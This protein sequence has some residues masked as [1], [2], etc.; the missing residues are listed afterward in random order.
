MSLRCLA[1]SGG[2]GGARLCQGLLRALPPDHLTV[3]VNT[4]DD[5]DHLGLRI[6]PDLD[7]VLYTLA[8]QGHEEQGWGLAEETFRIMERLATLGGPTWFRLGDLDLA[9]HLAR[10]ELLREGAS[11]EE[12]TRQL[13]RAMGVKATLLPMCEESVSTWLET[14]EGLL[15]FQGWFVQRAGQVPVTRVELRG[16]GAARLPA[17]AGGAL[18][19]A[20]LIVIGPSNPFVSVA[21]IQSVPGLAQAWRD[22]RGVKVAIS[23]IVGGQAVK[24]PAA[25]ML[26][27]LGHEVS[28]VGVAR[29]YQGWVDR[30][31]LDEQDAALAPSI[32]DLGM[33][34]LVLPTLMT[35]PARREAL[36]RAL[37][38]TLPG[39]GR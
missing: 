37:L 34:P 13:A 2:V 19:G 1:L 33:Q 11:L 28:A 20:D 7:T 39:G 16:I 21:P 18:A 22:A 30:F 29:L 32:Q 6:C 3:L 9:T 35:D 23:P 15:P 17:S 24:G 12:V 38:D 26:A 5:F 8:G 14:S 27:S 4:A 25:R 31:V 36:A 10:T